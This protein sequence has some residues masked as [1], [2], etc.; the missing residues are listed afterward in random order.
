MIGTQTFAFGQAPVSVLLHPDA[1]PVADIFRCI[2]GFQ[3]QYDLALLNGPEQDLCRLTRPEYAKAI[4]SDALLLAFALDRQ[5]TRPLCHAPLGSRRASTDEYCLMTLIGASRMRDSELAY[6]AS[7]VLGVASL[8][9]VSSL[10]SDLIGQ[11][12]AGGLVFRTP[13]IEEFRA[14]VGESLLFDNDA[15]VGF[16][17]SEMK[18]RF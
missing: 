18:F 9:L 15:E 11:I 1:V 2:S 3:D 4:I 6:E 5:R 14:L 8:D 17:R 12:D 13:D 16:E 7:S 10:A